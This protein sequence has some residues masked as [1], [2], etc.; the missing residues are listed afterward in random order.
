[1][2]AVFTATYIDGSM[3]YVATAKAVGLDD[4]NL[5]TA[6]MAADNLMMIFYFLVLFSLP[7]MHRLRSLFHE[8]PLSRCS[9]PKQNCIMKLHQPVSAIFCPVWL[10]GSS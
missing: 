3:N 5:L 4:G 6:S 10:P 7:S 1:L 2:A 9:L 8:R